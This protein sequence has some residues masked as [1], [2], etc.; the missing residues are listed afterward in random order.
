MRA[1]ASSLEGGE[2][3]NLALAILLSLKGALVGCQW[4]PFMHGF[5]G[6]EDDP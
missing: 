4:A 6:R 3:R 5:G 2:K 1:I